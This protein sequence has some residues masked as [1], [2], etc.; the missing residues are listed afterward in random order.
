[1][2]YSYLLGGN[3]KVKIVGDVMKRTVLLFIICVFIPFH[4]HAEETFNRIGVMIG[5]TGLL[6]AS[7]E[8]HFGNNSLRM[9]AG[10]VGPMELCVAITFNRYFFTSSKVKSY[11]G[12]GMWNVFLFTFKGIG[13]LDILNVPVGLDWQKSDR[14]SF[15]VE[16]DINFFLHGRDPGGEKVH[17]NRN[18]FPFPAVYFKHKL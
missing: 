4:S 16:T 13:R 6:S 10:I 3:I 9:N 11:A 5:G 15:G 1:M 8:H 17:F 12:V 7:L 2:K 14:N 18:W